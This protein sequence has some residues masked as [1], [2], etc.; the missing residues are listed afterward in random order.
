LFTALTGKSTLRAAFFDWLALNPD[1]VTV[2][3]HRDVA[4]GAP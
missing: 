1:V 2:F 4:G 3:P